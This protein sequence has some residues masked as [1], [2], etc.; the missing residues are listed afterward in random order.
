VEL[1]VVLGQLVFGHDLI[2]L[3]A[4]GIQP[5]TSVLVHSK[6]V[7]RY[8]LFAGEEA[9]LGIVK[10]TNILCL[11]NKAWNLDSYC[12]S[13]YQ[14]EHIWVEA[15]LAVLVVELLLLVPNACPLVS[16]GFL[17]IVPLLGASN[18]RMP[19]FTSSSR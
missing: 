9:T 12:N 5:T 6:H 13:T 19:L 18:A 3:V 14:F 7:A 1:G 17:S 4:V 10:K 2:A 15:S 8:R 16:A 11:K